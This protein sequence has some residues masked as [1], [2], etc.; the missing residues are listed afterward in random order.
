M[1]AIDVYVK[2]QEMLLEYANDKDAL[3]EYGELKTTCLDYKVWYDGL[4]KKMNT[5][6]H[7]LLDSRIVR[8]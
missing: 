3:N 4:I 8:K 7:M 2:A 5:T 6:Q 1:K